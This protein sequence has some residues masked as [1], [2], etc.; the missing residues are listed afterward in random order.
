MALIK[1]AYYYYVEREMY[2]EK[3][4]NSIYFCV[5][6]TLYCIDIDIDRCCCLVVVRGGRCC[7]V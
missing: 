1:I 3:E 7:C 5:L 2:K 6:V 4:R